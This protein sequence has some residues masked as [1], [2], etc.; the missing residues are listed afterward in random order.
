[1]NTPVIKA[2][3]GIRR[4][5]KSTLM[6]QLIDELLEQ[7]IETN[8]IIYINKELFEFDAIKTYRHLH[9]YIDSKTESRNKPN[10]VFLDEV[11]EIEEWERAV[12]SLLAQKNYDIYITG[13]N[14]HLLSSELATIISGRYVEFRMY[15]LTFSE[16]SSLIKTGNNIPATGDSF[17]IFLKYGGFPGIHSFEWQENSI[18]QYLHSLYSTILLK[19]VVVRYKIRDAAMLEKIMEYL[20]DNCGNITTAKNI[21]DFV[22]SQ[23]RNVAVD[24]VQNYIRYACNA[25][26]FQKTGRYDLKGKRLL[27]THEKYYLS[28]VG[29]RSAILGFTPEAL[30]G[31]LENIVLL[32]LLVRGFKVDIGKLFDKEIDFIARKGNDRIYLQVC[33]T[34]GDSRVVDREY[35][36]LEAI[37]DHFPKLVLSMDQGFETS[38]KGIR[39]KNLK[40]FLQPDDS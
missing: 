37:D 15:T 14:A 11:Q 28:D 7:G 1:M 2:I 24:T 30:P 13:S 9:E 17:D 36:S 23:Y 40:E 5:G 21:S 34:L 10:Y 19:D 6:L 22:K 16:F 8:R 29:I 27:E 33:T 4:C 31:Q 12:N 35:S 20:I 38:R 3:S 25:L 39:W 18:R 26:L 32:E